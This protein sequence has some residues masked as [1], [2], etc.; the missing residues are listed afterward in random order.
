M[1]GQCQLCRREADLQYGHIFPRFSIL[2]LKRT[3]ATGFLRNLEST[4]RAQEAKREYI[5]C[6]ECEQLLSRDEKTFA[7]EMFVPYHD[8]SQSVFEYGAWLRRFLAGLHFKVLVTRN[9]SLFPRSAAEVYAAAEEELRAFLLG[10]AETPGRAEFHVFFWDVI[11]DVSHPLPAKMNWYLARGFDATPVFAEA[12]AVAVY[13]KV[14]KIMTHA[15][16]TPRDGEKERWEGTQVFEEGVLRTPQQIHTASIW[17]FLESRAK[18]V[19]QAA[20]SLT[21]PQKQ[22]LAKSILAAPERFVASETF[23][24]HMA[25]A[26]LRSRIVQRETALTVPANVTKGRD[27]N[28]PCP[29][30][31]GWKTK[32]CHGA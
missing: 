11:K 16:L 20:L 14:I 1:I 31:S 13:A 17:P 7:E 21:A 12:G 23:R 29:C 25:D 26:V 27:R 32:R 24:T 4:K 8:R 19:E 15:F 5:L 10:R 3:S 18:A 30:G 28:Q 6:R 22:R 9:K 2:W